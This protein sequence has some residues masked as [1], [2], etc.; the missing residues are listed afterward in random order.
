MAE[1]GPTMAKEGIKAVEAEK[2]LPR[3][4]LAPPNAAAMQSTPTFKAPARFL[5]IFCVK[6][7]YTL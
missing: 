2:S 5:A 7:V 4:A 6:T 1:K 3:T